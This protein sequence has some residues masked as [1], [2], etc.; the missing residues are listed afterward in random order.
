MSP[1]SAL[2]KLSLV[3]FITMLTMGFSKA[4]EAQS[5]DWTTVGAAGTVDEDDRGIVLLGSPIPGAVT[6]P[7]AAIGVLNIR[8]NVVAVDGVFGGS[9]IFSASFQDNGPNARVIVRLK[10]QGL[11]TG[12]TTTLLTLDSNA[13]P[14]SSRFQVQSAGPDCSGAALNFF[15]NAYFMDVEITKTKPAGTPVLGMIRL[16]VAPC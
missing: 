14:A 3:L 16:S 15:E 12:I 6:M 4:A 9:I 2:F 1:Q 10:Q 5:K 7:A 11:N 8:Y 13:F